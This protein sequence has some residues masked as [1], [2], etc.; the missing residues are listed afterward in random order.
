MEDGKKA[1]KLQDLVRL[2]EIIIQNLKELTNLP[3]LEEDEDL[4]DT[5]EGQIFAYKAHR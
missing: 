1:P 2:Q 5:V 3:G 4:K